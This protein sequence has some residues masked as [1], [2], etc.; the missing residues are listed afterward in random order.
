MQKGWLIS[1]MSGQNSNNGLK[2]C[3]LR[4]FKICK[5]QKTPAVRLRFSVLFDAWQLYAGLS[6]PSPCGQPPAVQKSSRH[7]CPPLESGSPT[8]N[9]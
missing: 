7:F 9:R 2:R 6:C 3:R 1:S 8:N 4:R 5:K